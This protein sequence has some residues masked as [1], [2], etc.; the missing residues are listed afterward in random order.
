MT[1]KTKPIRYEIGRLSREIKLQIR[2]D[3]EHLR[4][5]TFEKFINKTGGIK[6]ALKVLSDRTNWI[7][8]IK[9]RNSK[10]ATKRLDILSTA[11]NFYRN[12]YSRKNQIEPTELSSDGNVP[13]IL[14]DE[15]HKAIK[16][17]KSDKA[18]GPDQIN[19]ELLLSCRNYIVPLLTYTFNDILNTE[20]IPTQWTASTIILLH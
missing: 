11:T 7:V 4:L 5:N 3:R 10:T 6:K 12:L 14:E 2:K 20:T 17:Q 18:P 16:T 8:N 19:N 1:N 15:I 9:D 13:T